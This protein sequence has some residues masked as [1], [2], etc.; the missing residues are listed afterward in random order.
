MENKEVEIQKLNET[1]KLNNK[2]LKVLAD[3]NLIFQK[4]IK[5]NERYLNNFK[6]NLS[7]EMKSDTKLICLIFQ[8]SQQTIHYPI[9]CTNKMIFNNVENILYK[10]FPQYKDSFNFF[11]VGG[12]QINA[13]RTLEENN[14]KYGDVILMTE[15]ENP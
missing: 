8:N 9:L 12:R 4:T 7:I 13:S 6:S 10:E 1:I 14:I 15:F 5:E 3:N 11:Y 2:Q